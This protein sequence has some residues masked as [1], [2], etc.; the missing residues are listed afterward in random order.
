MAEQA[1]YIVSATHRVVAELEQ[2]VAGAKP[3]AVRKAVLRPHRFALSLAQMLPRIR[4]ATSV[5]GF[6]PTRVAACELPSDRM[7]VPPPDDLIRHSYDRSYDCSLVR[8]LAQ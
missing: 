8:L 2:D 6:R 1:R 4:Q 3:S 5:V 7:T